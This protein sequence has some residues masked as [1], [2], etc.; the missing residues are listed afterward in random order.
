MHKPKKKQ[1]FQVWNARSNRCI[2]TSSGKIR[3]WIKYCL[4]R[5]AFPNDIFQFKTKNWVH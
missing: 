1:T 3:A 2:Y 5:W 4:M